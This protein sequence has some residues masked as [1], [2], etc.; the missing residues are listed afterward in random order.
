MTGEAMRL[1]RRR[2]IEDIT[3]RKIPAIRRIA[4]KPHEGYTHT[5]KKFE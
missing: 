1:L 3:I 2:M 5:V 4:A